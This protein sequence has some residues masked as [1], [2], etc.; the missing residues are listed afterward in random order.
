MGIT[1]VL[2]VE[3]AEGFIVI[4][5]PSPIPG[6]A[7]KKYSNCVI[8]PAVEAVEEV[9]KNDLDSVIL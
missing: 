3:S 4:L 7:S 8:G 9:I 2:S 1:A 6:S 5:V